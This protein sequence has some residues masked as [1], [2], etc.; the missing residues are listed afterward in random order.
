M[1][2]VRIISGTILFTILVIILIFGNTTV[3]NIVTALIGLIAINEYFNAFRKK[4]RVE[5]IVGDILAI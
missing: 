3:V 5:R 1:K 2:K 4:Y